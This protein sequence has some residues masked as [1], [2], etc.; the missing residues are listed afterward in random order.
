MKLSKIYSTDKKFNSVCFNDNFN[1]VLGNVTN[2]NELNKDSHNLG[3]STLI[4][5]IDFLLLK[6]ID[7]KHFLKKQ[8]FSNHYFYLEIK[9]NDGKYV[10]ICRGVEKPSK[11]NMAIHS[12][13][14]QDYRLNADWTYEELALGSSDESKNP[15]SIL[16]KLLNFDVLKGEM[17][18]KTSGYFLR[19]QDDYKDVFKLQ[20][21]KGKDVD[22]KPIL[23]ELL[24]FNSDSMVNKYNIE[25]EI[26]N[27]EKL[28]EQVKMEFAVDSGEKDRINGLINVTEIE[29]DKIVA[30][31]D[32]FDF[33]QKEAGLSK[34]AV[35]DIERRIASLNTTRY[36]LE[37]EISQINQSLEAKTNY[38]FDDILELYKE[39][40]VY[41]PE[42][43]TKSYQELV[44]FNNKLAS[45]RLKYL[46]TSLEHKRDE[47]K[48][49]NQELSALNLE[50]TQMLGVLKETNTFDKYNQYRNDLIEIERKIERYRM[51]LESIDNVKKIQK[52][53][54]KLKENLAIETEKLAAQIDESTVIYKNIRNDFHEYVNY[55]LDKN[56]MISIVINTNG[57]IEFDASFYNTSNEETAQGLGHT[58]RKLLCACFD[59]AVI[60]NYMNKSF[61]RFIYHDGCLESL[62][63]RKRVK[64]LRLVKHISQ[65]YNIQ[66]IL[67]SLSTDIPEN[68]EVQSEDIAVKL[69]DAE[70]NLGRLF[71]FEF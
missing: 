60:K 5:L 47:V 2:L 45:E 20:K 69:T 68:I 58:Y 55:I 52:D 39:V 15:K 10:T 34:K 65:K 13:G 27:K 54:N 3:K 30:W 9:L 57:N 64:Y 56:A 18:R 31:L 44:E 42:T 29:R 51:E 48:K 19:T 8:Q 66:Y 32:K 17:Y 37:Y 62:D 38:N 21:Y 70:D 11:V 59:L 46:K 1:I 41:F 67:T 4:E 6:D 50:R 28:I 25:T 24:G 23:F 71:G 26:T 7:K 63:P 35:E 43:L 33:F 12:M 40:E 49:V 22:W 14:N 61:Y 16:N 36:N 53:I